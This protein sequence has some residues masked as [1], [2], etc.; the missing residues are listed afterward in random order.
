[1]ENK[2]ETT[3]PHYVCEGDAICAEVDG[4]FV[5][6]K[7]FRDNDSGTPEEKVCGFWPSTNPQDAGYIGEEPEVSY[8]EQLKKANEVLAAWKRDEWFYGGVVLSVSKRIK[9]DGRAQREVV[10]SEHAA[11]LWGIECNYPDTNNEYLTEVANEL[12]PEALTY[13]REILRQLIGQLT[14]EEKPQ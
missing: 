2:F 7:I 4:F 5:V 1:M 9:I 8:S 3:F 13:A 12:L 10:L 11:S 14:T 6:A